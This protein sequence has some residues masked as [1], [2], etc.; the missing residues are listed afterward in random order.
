MDQTN[1]NSFFLVYPVNPIEQD[2]TLFI[3]ILDNLLLKFIPDFMCII[4][5]SQLSYLDHYLRFEQIL[6]LFMNQLL[7]TFLHISCCRNF[8]EGFM[9]LIIE[10]IFDFFSLDVSLFD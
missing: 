7:R 3:V 4:N 9:N 6:Q 10:F 1:L 8:I 2:S 5:I